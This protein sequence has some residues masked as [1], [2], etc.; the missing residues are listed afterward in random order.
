[1]NIWS[2]GKADLYLFKQ[3]KALLWKIKLNHVD[4][5]IHKTQMETVTVPITSKTKPQT[6]LCLF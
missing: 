1:M 4:V 5:E 2:K 6:G 3:I